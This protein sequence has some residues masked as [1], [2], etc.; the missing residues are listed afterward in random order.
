MG[1]TSNILIIVALVALAVVLLLGV[2]NMRGTGNPQ[3]SQRL[4]RWRIGLQAG[5]IILLLG[6]VYFGRG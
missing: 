2:W 6:I 3:R 4:M 1:S 5:I